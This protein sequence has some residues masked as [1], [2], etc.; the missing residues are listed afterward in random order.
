MGQRVY[1]GKGKY[2]KMDASDYYSSVHGLKQYVF[3]KQGE[4]KLQLQLSNC[5]VTEEEDDEEEDPILVDVEE[6]PKQSCDN[7]TA[8]DVSSQLLP[9][10]RLSHTT[11]PDAILYPATTY[12]KSF[13]HDSDSSNYTH[14][15]GETNTTVDYISAHEPEHLDEEYQD[16]EDDEEQFPFMMD[17]S[18]SHCNAR[19]EMQIGGKLTLDTVK[20]NCSNL[21][22]NEHF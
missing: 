4:M 6:L 18:P 19:E 10:T 14:T 5:S 16:G 22:Q 1:P 12:I 13:S 3:L 20:I 21:F 15:S 8:P 7:S 11:E 2:G 17:F 9:Q